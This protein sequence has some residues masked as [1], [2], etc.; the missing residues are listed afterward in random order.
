ML[1]IEISFRDPYALF[2]D[3][4]GYVQEIADCTA[5]G[6]SEPACAYIRDHTGRLEPIIKSLD[7]M[8]NN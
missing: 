7:A 1:E 2:V 8:L 6:D 4:S 5:S 3:T